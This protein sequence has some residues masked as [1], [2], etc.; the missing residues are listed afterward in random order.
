MVFKT[1][2]IDRR[3]PLREDAFSFTRRTLFSSLDKRNTR[4]KA[5][6]LP[7]LFR[8]AYRGAVSSPVVVLVF[9]PKYIVGY[10]QKERVA[11]DVFDARRSGRT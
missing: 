5:K 2:Y 4:D 9:F 1:T 11:H 3:K 8:E 10:P 6:V 7:D